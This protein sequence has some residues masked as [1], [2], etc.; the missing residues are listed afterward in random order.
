MELHCPNKECNWTWDY[1]GKR[2]YPA[3]VTCPNCLGRVKLPK[4]MNVDDKTSEIKKQLLQRAANKNVMKFTQLDWVHVHGGDS[5]DDDL[6][7]FDDDDDGMMY[8]HTTDLRNSPDI[9]VVRIQISE[10]TTR[11]TVVRVLKKTVEW[12]DQSEE[13]IMLSEI[14]N[15]SKG[16]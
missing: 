11:A 13:R 3:W 6:L 15:T 1:H 7:V 16:E 2:R 4:M 8:G 14:D 12:L 10:P 9:L 5:C